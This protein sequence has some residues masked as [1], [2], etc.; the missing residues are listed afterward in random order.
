[1]SVL[2]RYG[3][4]FSL[5]LLLTA[6]GGGDAEKPWEETTTD[7]GTTTNPDE[8]VVTEVF[9]GSGAG[10]TF[11]AGVLDVALTT[12]SAGGSSAVSASLADADGNLYQDNATVM[13]TSACS[14]V[15]LASLE[16]PVLVSGGVASTTYTANGCTGDD[17]IT[18]TS[19]V[20]DTTLSATG[21]ISV[22][23]AT[24]GSLQFVEAVPSAIGISG[25]G[26]TEVSRVSFKVLDTTNN[27]AMYASVSFELNTNV[28]GITLTDT[29]ATSDKDGLVYVYVNSGTVAT[30][31]RVTATLDSN[32]AIKT[33]SDGL[34]IST[35]VA[36]Q[37][38]ISLSVSTHNPEAWTNDGVEVECNV[39][40]ADHFNN[41]V[42]DG[43]AVYFTTEGG[44]IEPSCETVNG[45]C[46][47]VWTS[48]NPR[49]DNGRSTL[50]ATMIG[51][52]T[53]IDS[54]PSNG[55]LDNLDTFEDM[56]E[57][58][59]DDDE[60]GKFTPGV[61]EYL[62]FDSDGVYDT[63]D[64]EFNG[65]LCCDATAVANA[66]SGDACFGMT[67]TSEV[68]S[69]VKNI[70]VRAQQILVMAASALSFATDKLILDG[71]GETSDGTYI[72]V[73]GVHADDSW[74]VPPSGTEIS[75]TVNNGKLES[76]SSIVVPDLNEAGP[77]RTWVRWR[78]D[79]TPSNGTLSVTATTP[80]GLK[81]GTLYID[82]VD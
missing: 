59:R 56:P 76:D 28:G 37:N 16:S 42:P 71:S 44:Q 14:S 81:S 6:C 41:P 57:A 52:E 26:L 12:I 15:G 18:A 60:N 70:N 25:F 10:D 75:I 23:P 38:S 66:E 21:T 24:V 13:F 53:F 2:T 11:T 73:F 29:T 48:S 67:P 9:L 69:A 33:Q 5:S 82:L 20:N 80:G 61:E 46:S 64:G 39:F 58:F 19:T 55:L 72:Y 43:T 36:D 34:V 51:E 49:P 1:M 62:D 27:P 77:Y 30:V 65:V 50:L 35:G 3:L 7:D 74:Q 22:L 63:G 54:Q 78:G 68:C 79:T 40:A 32:P 45:R 4:V 17:T 31:V 47:V 8:A